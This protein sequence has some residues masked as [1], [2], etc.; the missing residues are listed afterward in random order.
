VGL[1]GYANDLI[2]LEPAANEGYVF[3]AASSMAQGRFAGAEAD[4][5][6]A[7]QV[8]PESSVGYVEM[9]S[10]NFN[11]QNL[12]AAES[13]YEQ[14]LSHDP[15]SLHAL[16]GLAKVYLSRK[17]PDKAIDR[18]NAQIARSPNNS[19]FYHLLGTLEFAKGD[20]PPAETAFAKSAQ[21][22]KNDVDSYLKLGQVQ[23]AM[24]KPY[25]ALSTWSEGARENPK[26][27]AFYTARG[28][29]YAQENDH[30]S[31]KSCYEMAL[32]LKPGDAGI[33]N[34]LAYALLLTNGNLNRALELA[35]SARR[36]MP[37]SPEAADT[38]G[39]V[40]YQKGNYE[41]AIDM[42]QEA[43]RLAAKNKQGENPTY[44]FQLGLSYQKSEKLRLARQTFERVLR[45]DPNFGAA[46]YI[47]RQLVQPKS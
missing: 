6:K 27:V 15:N 7:I 29:L 19:A 45:I 13:W 11:E 42:F 25:H 9:G 2:R 31:A 12:P 26:E 16:E 46:A 43:I 30:E 8:A 4:V 44:Y 17:R 24:G 22:N 14:A 36:G 32:Q 40:L 47:R 33:S 35:Q 21:L 3:R 20:L 39:L 5:R 10:L 18:V 37:G 38:L 34:N 23:Q 41:S 1:A 28:L